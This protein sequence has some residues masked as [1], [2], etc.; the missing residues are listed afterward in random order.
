MIDCIHFYRV[1]HLDDVVKFYEQLLGLRLYKDQKKCLIYDT[2][3]GKIGFC[4][5]FP[6]QFS[7]HTCITFVYK[8]QFEV[9]KMYEK[10]KALNI[11]NKPP[12]R[13]ETFQI[14][15][16]FVKDFCGL[17]VEFQCFY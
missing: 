12:E 3:F 5:H 2:G 4:S 7:D 6:S 16:F 10:L 1:S 11:A 13:S 9:D 8:D 14:Y 15:H 17:N